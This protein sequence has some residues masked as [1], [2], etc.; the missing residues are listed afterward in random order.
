MIP[1][2]P[3]EGRLDSMKQDRST[4]GHQGE[5]SILNNESKELINETFAL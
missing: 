2:G 5:R 1:E 3:L 4:T